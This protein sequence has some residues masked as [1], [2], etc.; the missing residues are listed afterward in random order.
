[1]P[2]LGAAYSPRA[3]QCGPFF[4]A[5]CLMAGKGQV[6]FVVRL[7][8]CV[9]V[10]RFVVVVLRRVYPGRVPHGAGPQCGRHA[11]LRFCAWRFWALGVRSGPAAG[12]LSPGH[13][14]VQGQ[15]PNILRRRRRRS[16]ASAHCP[17][18][19]PRLAPHGAPILLYCTVSH[20]SLPCAAP[21]LWARAHA[22]ARPQTALPWAALP[23]RPL[24]PPE[25]GRAGVRMV[26]LSHR[27]DSPLASKRGDPSG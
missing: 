14:R 9:A 8:R 13:A 7:R 15:S 2:R 24:S 4:F 3:G 10:D 19:G 6:P 21:L 25:R 12:H 26:T 1:M 20:Q 5:L 23:L 11:T 22:H 18:P 17:R 27:P 16:P